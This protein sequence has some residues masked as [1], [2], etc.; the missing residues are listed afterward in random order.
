MR[1]E[2]NKLDESKYPFKKSSE[3][4]KYRDH[5]YQDENFITH[6]QKEIEERYGIRPDI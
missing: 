1:V 6:G 4:Q 5:C 3:T 2:E